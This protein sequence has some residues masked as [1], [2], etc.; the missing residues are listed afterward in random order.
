VGRFTP[1]S[2][3]ASCSPPRIEWS[4]RGA[5]Y[6]IQ[7]NV[8]TQRTERRILVRMANSAIRTGPRGD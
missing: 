8:G 4:E 7:A 5:T 6:G 3:G 2:C 1:L